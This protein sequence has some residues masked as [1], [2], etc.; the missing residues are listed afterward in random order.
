MLL[1]FLASPVLEFGSAK[2][3]LCYLTA[4]G[5]LLQRGHFCSSSPYMIKGEIHLAPHTTLL[6]SH[7]A[8]TSVV[9]SGGAFWI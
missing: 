4:A 9:L 1:C 8:R 2:P 6:V 5:L 3:D 7:T